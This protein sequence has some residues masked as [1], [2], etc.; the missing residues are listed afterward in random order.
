M[1]FLGKFGP[2]NP[3]QNDKFKLKLVRL[4][5]VFRIEWGWSLF[6]FSSRTPLP[7]KFVSQN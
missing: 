1:P 5:G 3:K 6:L 7:Y 4:I 2:K